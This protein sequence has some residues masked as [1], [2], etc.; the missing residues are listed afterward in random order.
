[1][2][3]YR[4]P[5]SPTGDNRV[6]STVPRPLDRDFRIWR[7]PTNQRS[8]SVEKTIASAAVA[9]LPAASVTEPAIAPLARERTISASVY[10]PSAPKSNGTSVTSSPPIVIDFMYQPDGNS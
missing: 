8:R 7:E 6:M 2:S 3:P 4:A 10:L 1:G 9:R 5:R